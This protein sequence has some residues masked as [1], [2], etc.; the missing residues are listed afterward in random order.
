MADITITYADGS[1][2][3]VRVLPAD[4]V[5]FERQFS[6]AV[7][8]AERE[9]HVLWLYWHALKRNGRAS[10]DFDAWLSSVTEYGNPQ[11]PEV[12]SVP[13]ASTGS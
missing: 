7:F 9:E 2:D 4:R 5:A 1:T 11:E 12:P 3:S 8:S 13:V 10:A 6:I